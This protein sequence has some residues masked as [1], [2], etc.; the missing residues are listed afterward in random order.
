M[1]YYNK[2]KTFKLSCVLSTKI[3]LWSIQTSICT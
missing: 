2:E 1:P 3:W